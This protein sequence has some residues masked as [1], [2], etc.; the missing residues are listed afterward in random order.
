MGYHQS[1]FE[2]VG[3][4]INPQ[5][6]FPFEFHRGDAI[7]F[8]RRHGHEFDFI[9]G[10]P[11]CQRYSKAQRIRKRDHPDLIG[12]FRSALVATG[13]PYVIEN[14]EEARPELRSPM[15]LC[16]LSFGLRTD[17]HRL[18]ESNLPLSVPEHPAHPKGKTKM[19]RPF[20]DGELRQ[21]VGNFSGVQAAR[22]DLGVHWMNRDGIR[23]C[24]PPAYAH[25]LGEQ[26]RAYLDAGLT[27]RSRRRHAPG[28]ACRTDGVRV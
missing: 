20:Q 21:Y 15:M 2:I 1:G 19:G 28:G 9:A 11:P 26:V 10:G 7:E 5:P 18:F 3:V 4:D 17:R 25:H 23:E 24:I 16:G 12:E 8:V 6:R 13:K 22:E 27:V 14:V